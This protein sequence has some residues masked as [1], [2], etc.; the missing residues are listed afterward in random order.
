MFSAADNDYMRRALALAERGLFSISTHPRVGCV[1]VK[2]GV[3]VGEGFHERAGEPH[4]EVHALRTAGALAA[5]A[6]VSVT[7][8][9]C[10]HQGRTPP[11]APK[12]IEAK[13]ARVVVAMHDP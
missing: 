5:G 13:V 1:F 9:P 6:T 7:L 11:C 4:A 10:S 3:I 12:L 2:D 8:E